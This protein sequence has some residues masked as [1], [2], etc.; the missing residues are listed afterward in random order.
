MNLLRVP[1]ITE[2]IMF[3]QTIVQSTC[4]Y[5][6][7]VE[8]TSWWHFAPQFALVAILAVFMQRWYFLFAVAF[9]GILA[10]GVSS[11]I[12]T[13]YWSVPNLDHVGTRDI[14]LQQYVTYLVVAATIY[15]IKR[16]ASRIMRS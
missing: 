14:L 8:P 10:D 15:A 2:A 9:A 13:G 12:S 16:F 3:A 11:G 7:C 4:N 5:G 6:P 1:I